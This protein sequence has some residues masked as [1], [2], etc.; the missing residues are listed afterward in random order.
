MLAWGITRAESAPRDATTTNHADGTPS[1]DLRGALEIP[2]TRVAELRDQALSETLERHV[3]QAALAVAPPAGAVDEYYERFSDRY[4][5]PEAIEVWRILLGTEQQAKALLAEVKASA[6]P[7]KTWSLAAREHSLDKATHFRKGYLGFVRADGSTDVPQVRVSP[8]IFAAA[9]ALEDGAMGEAPFREGEHWGLVWRRG[10]R[11]AERRTVERA[12]DE[13]TQQLAL[14]AAR[15]SL[16]D[17]LATLRTQHLT[18]YHPELVEGLARSPDPGFTVQRPSRQA[19]PAAGDPT[20][21]KTDW[22]ER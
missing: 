18:D 6:T 22:G 10:F 19:R 17:L 13:I 3:L 1:L 15:T 2:A 14:A 8:A 16:T 12:R 5:A 21:R 11:K 20:P 4:V 7:Q 9:R